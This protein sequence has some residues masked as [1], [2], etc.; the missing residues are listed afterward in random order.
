MLESVLN[1]KGFEVPV[2]LLMKQDQN[3]HDFTG[4]HL[5]GPISGAGRSGERGLLGVL[6]S[7]VLGEV[8][9]VAEQLE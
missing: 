5:Q 3:G 2:A 9:N 8:I 4:L 7:E 6:P 1:V